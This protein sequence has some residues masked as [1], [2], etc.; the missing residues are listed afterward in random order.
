M[1]FKNPRPAS[2]P[3]ADFILGNPPF[4][5]GK[6]KR[7]I[8]GQGYF[9]ALAKVYPELPESCDLVMYWWHKAAE[10]VRSKKA[11]DFGFITTN[12]ISQAF[13]RRIIA[14]HLDAGLSVTF[15][16]PDHPWVDSADGA[17]V[18][19]A[20]TVGTPGQE[21]G[22]V[23]TVTQ[24]KEGPDVERDVTLSS[25]WG[26]V[27]ADLT[28]GADIAA[29][30][31]LR[32]NEKISNRGV[33]LHG[34]GFIVSPNEAEFLGFG[35][36]PGLEKHIRHYRNGRDLTGKSRDV[37][38][39]DLF[40]LSESEIIERFPAVYQ[41]VAE[42]V[43]PERDHNPRESRRKNWWLFGETISTFRP[44]L[45]G[46]QR[47]I[48][49]VETAKHRVFVFLDASILPDNMLVNIATDDA[50]VLGVLCSRLHVTWALAAGGRLG[51]GND[52]RYNKSRCFETFPFPAADE[53]QRQR[54]RDLGERLD[55]HRKAR[56]AEH[57]DLTLTG[58]YN[59]L[60]RLRSGQPFTPAEKKA[61]EQ[62]LGTVLLT[63]HNELDAA[64]ADAYGWPAH[65]SEPEIL[66]RLVDL[67]AV[68]AAEEKKGL[69]RWLRPEYQAP[70]STRKEETPSLPIA[71]AQEQQAKRKPAEQIPWP[72]DEAGRIALLLKT[73]RALGREATSDEIAAGI[74]GASAA[75]IE[76][77][78][79]S[80]AVHGLIRR[81]EKGYLG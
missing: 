48:S 17:A 68:R 63:L 81:G 76:R 60:E 8:L 15:A 54:I 61:H 52:P 22:E 46:L 58:M 73:L 20:L 80:L 74:K 49:T 62:A 9:E 30:L 4:L 44:A 59:A 1:I 16:I 55:A 65:L 79:Q 45:A 18:R 12:S 19:I 66:T 42:R 67:N 3:E 50:F 14:L 32:A 7:N 10:I 31:S 29:T 47:Y 11:L 38:V 5:G 34:S 51:M 72:K 41:W 24:E 75:K 69:I 25:Q 64:V 53:S 57:P 70:E 56:Q 37:M 35:R 26:R 6:D 33:V 21:V 71:Q 39:I 77:V 36:I 13:N 23:Q 28:V 78:A 43:K 40:G 27:N 2:W